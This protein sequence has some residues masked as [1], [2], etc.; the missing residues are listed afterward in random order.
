MINVL[1][2]DDQA[3]MRLLIQMTIESADGP[4]RVCGVA[5]SAAEAISLV[6]RECPAV[7]V[8]DHT[9]P[10]MTGLEVT[11]HLR[12]R[13]PC[14]KILLFSAYLDDAVRQQAD[15]LAVAWLPKDELAQLPTE[16]RRVAA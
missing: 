6:Q 8:L 2:V 16:I 7:V 11:E 13:C 1:V 5:A 15:A 4:F 10:G 9:M 14:L 12:T 3:D